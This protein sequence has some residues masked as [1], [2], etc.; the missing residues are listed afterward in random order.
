ME[1]FKSLKMSQHN[2]NILEDFIFLF[3]LRSR[4]KTAFTHFWLCLGW[5]SKPRTQKLSLRWHQLSISRSFCEIFFVYMCMY[6][7]AKLRLRLI[8]GSKSRKEIMH[9][10]F[11][12]AQRQIWNYLNINN[13]FS[14]N[15]W[16]KQYRRADE[17]LYLAMRSMQPRMLN[18]T[19]V[20]LLFMPAATDGITT[21]QRFN[22]AND[23]ARTRLGYYWCVHWSV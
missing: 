23:K 2:W 20:P 12:F 14:I 4:L 11:S 6:M 8:C 10:S 22:T 1:D 16:G 15:T 17:T 3:E 13:N 19:R 18:K 9:K 7:P 5:N 21:F